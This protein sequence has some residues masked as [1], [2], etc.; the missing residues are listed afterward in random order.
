[1]V[2]GVK[3]KKAGESALA[4]YS[5]MADPKN[6]VIAINTSEWPGI[7]T[8]MKIDERDER[9]VDCIQIELWR[10]NPGGITTDESVDPLSLWLSL[11]YTK[12]ERIEMARDE[13][14]ENIWSKPQW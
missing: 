8:L 14:I 1:L 13:L 12:D 10:Y 5:M 7:K 2:E 6:R 11:E 9:D 4:E 3:A